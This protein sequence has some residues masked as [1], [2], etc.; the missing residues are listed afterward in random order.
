[1]KLVLGLN[2]EKLEKNFKEIILKLF[3]Q[4]SPNFSGDNC[5]KGFL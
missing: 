1:M 2:F 4:N 3:L 5:K